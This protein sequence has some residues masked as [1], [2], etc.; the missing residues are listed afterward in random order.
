[1]NWKGA[2]LLSLIVLG[3][4]GCV[5]PFYGTARI[6]EGWSLDVGVAFMSEITP[7]MDSWAPEY[8]YG[9]RADAELRYGFCRHFQL[10]GRTAL[11]GAVA[12]PPILIDG[13]LGA[14]AA[15]PIGSLTPAIRVEVSGYSS[16]LTLSPSFLIGVGRTEWLTLGV[17]T[18]ILGDKGITPH[19]EY[20]PYI[21]PC[22]IDLF[23]GVHFGR[24]NVF[25]GSQ[26][27]RYS[28]FKPVVTLGVGYKLK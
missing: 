3:M 16:G 28:Y 1:M 8:S 12:W 14:Q 27:F 5:A 25:V 6:E 22:P 24:W 17:R 15:L 19:P 2:F 23:A 13:G 26:V 11:G 18:H 9:I 21:E 20:G 4:G 10:Y 7:S